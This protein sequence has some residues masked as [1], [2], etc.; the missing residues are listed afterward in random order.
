MWALEGRQFSDEAIVSV[1]DQDYTDLLLPFGADVPLARALER[2][3][4]I[5]AVY[6]DLR[7][8]DVVIVTLGFVDAWFDNETNLYLNRM[9]PHAF[10]RKNGGRFVFKRLGVS[11]VIALLEPAFNGLLTCGAR[12]VLTVSPVPIQ[13]TFSDKDCVVANE[14]S[15]SVLRVCADHLSNKDGVDYFPSY[16]IV[17]SGGLAAYID[18]QVHVR[19]DVVR[20]IVDYMVSVY[21]AA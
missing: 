19:D 5:G 1:N 9:P 10:A 2:R 16:E 20:G 21:S 14:Y 3:R 6:G 8:A 15:K 17:R 18:D 12:I 13:T 7:A 4:D 11:D